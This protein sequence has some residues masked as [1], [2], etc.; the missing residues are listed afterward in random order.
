[1]TLL[2]AADRLGGTTAISGAGIWI[3]A[4]PWA[5]RDI[6]DSPDEAFRYLR[7]L[8]LGDADPA[9]AEVHVRQGPRVIR[10]IEQATPLRWHYLIGFP[11]YHA[12][13]DGGKPYGRS[14]EIDPVRLP[15]EAPLGSGRTRTATPR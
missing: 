15:P 8:G 12:E 14:L 6:E 13:L 5:A 7:A 3:P 11:D 1:M 2:E 10:A 9:L 4:N